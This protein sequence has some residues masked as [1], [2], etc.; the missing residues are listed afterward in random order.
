MQQ[1]GGSGKRSRSIN[2]VCK[3]IFAC[4]ARSPRLGGVPCKTVIDIKHRPFG[5]AQGRLLQTG[6]ASAWPPPPWNRRRWTALP[7]TGPSAM[8]R[9]GCFG[10]VRPAHSPRRRGTGGA[11]PLFPAPALRQAQGRLLQAGAAGA[12]PPPPWN[13]RRWA[14]LPSTGAS[15]RCGHRRARPASTAQCP[16]APTRPARNSA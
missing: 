10:S 1:R 6:A 12:Q 15:G 7:S 9:A 11:G 4:K 13:R 5:Y 3:P 2:R 14:T 8:L 16:P